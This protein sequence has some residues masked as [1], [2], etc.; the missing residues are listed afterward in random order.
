V[1]KPDLGKTLTSILDVRHEEGRIELPVKEPIHRELE[2]PAHRASA[3]AKADDL[4]ASIRG[5][6]AGASWFHDAWTREALDQLERSFESACERW[7]SLYRSA[8]RQREL[9][10]KII[11]DHAR[12]DAERRVS[13]F[14]VVSRACSARSR[15]WKP[16]WPLTGRR[17]ACAACSL[18][19]SRIVRVAFM[20][21]P[22]LI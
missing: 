11:L 7:R 22:W 19:S 6:L 20:D 14:P 16:P 15:L 18:N 10:H 2:N 1:A 21:T 12:P 9:H 3:L 8:V 5:H 13:T 17:S 4:I